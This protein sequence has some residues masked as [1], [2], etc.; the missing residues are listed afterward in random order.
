MPT[1]TSYGYRQLTDQT[2]HLVW[3]HPK[4]GH[5][6]EARGWEPNDWQVAEVT[7]SGNNSHTLKRKMTASEAVDYAAQIAKSAEP[8]GTP[9]DFDI[10]GL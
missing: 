5:I 10:G 1:P 3:E 6:I 9:A 4:T 2:R 8:N 7:P